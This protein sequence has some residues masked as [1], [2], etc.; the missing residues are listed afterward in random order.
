[1]CTWL[2]IQMAGWTANTLTGVN[3]FFVTK[4]DS[5]GNKVRT[6]QLGVLGQDTRAY[7]VAVDSLG[8]VYV[9]GWTSGGLDTNTLTGTTDFFVTK[10]DSS[11]NYLQTQQLGVLGQD[12]RAYGVAVD[13]LDNVYVAG[14]TGGGLDTNTLTGTTDCFVTKYDSS[15]NNVRTQQLGVPGKEARAYRVAVDSSSNVYVAGYTDGGLDSN[16]LTGMND[17]FVTMYDS[18]GNKV[19]TKQLG[20]LGQDTV[21]LRRCRG[22]IWAMCTWLATQMAGWTTNTLTGAEDFFVTMYDPSG[23]KK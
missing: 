12:T 9:A 21:C 13:S 15:L 14:W 10:Y 23:N 7:G 17:F 5:L 18:L 4:Y 1:M 3:D 16:T 20:V 6:Q 22:F 8:N 2:A 19:R 11:L